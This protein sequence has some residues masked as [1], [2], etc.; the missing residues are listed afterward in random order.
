MS[1]MQIKLGHY[2]DDSWRMWLAPARESLEAAAVEEPGAILA[3]SEVVA[4]CREH[5]ATFDCLATAAAHYGLSAGRISQIQTGKD[6]GCPRVL[7]ALG[8][9]RERGGV[10]RRIGE[11]VV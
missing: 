4:I 3:E 7:S 11:G 2:W 5:F 8:I 1:G 6:V 10:F 9:R